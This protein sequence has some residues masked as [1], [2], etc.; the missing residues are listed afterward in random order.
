MGVAEMHA[1]VGD[2]ELAEHRAA[3]AAFQR[4]GLTRLDGPWRLR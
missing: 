3:V 1:Q 4:A 2:L